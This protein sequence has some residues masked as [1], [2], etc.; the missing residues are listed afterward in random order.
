M[1]EWVQSSCQRPKLR[2]QIVRLHMNAS[3]N[4]LHKHAPPSLL[5]TPR[6]ANYCYTGIIPNFR[7][8]E[9]NCFH[10]PE[11]NFQ[12]ESFVNK[13]GQVKQKSESVVTVDDSF[14]PRKVLNARALSNQLRMQNAEQLVYSV[15]RVPSDP[16]KIFWFWFMSIFIDWIFALKLA[17][18]TKEY[19][20]IT[21][22]PQRKK[23]MFSRM[24]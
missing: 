7:I 10:I 2:L 13:H 16:F 5:D 23:Q 6:M 18:Y 11:K 3:L 20:R 8:R 15:Q 12:C 9:C 21:I 24:K 17:I 4:K 14:P 22:Q 19:W 1:N